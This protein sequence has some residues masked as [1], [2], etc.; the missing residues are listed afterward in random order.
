MMFTGKV[1]KAVRH[2]GY[3]TGAGVGA[4]VGSYAVIEGLKYAGQAAEAMQ[5]LPAPQ[6]SALDAVPYIVGGLAA[7]ATLVHNLRKDNSTVYVIRP[8][9]D[10]AK[11]A[12]KVYGSAKD[13]ASTENQGQ[14]ERLIDQFSELASTAEQKFMLFFDK[15]RRD[16]VYVSVLERSGNDWKESEVRPVYVLTKGKQ[17]Y[18]FKSMDAYLEWCKRSSSATEAGV[19]LPGGDVKDKSAKKTKKGKKEKPK[20]TPKEDKP[21]VIK[22]EVTAKAEAKGDKSETVTKKTKADIK[23]D[24]EGAKVE[25]DLPVPPESTVS[26]EE[27]G[28]DI[29]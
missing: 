24:D 6:V 14:L 20:K 3:A 4:G 18:F 25:T 26:D 12:R 2:A 22:V 16:T 1:R 9:K 27:L 29:F 15:N 7:I 17:P 23:V 8:S 28:A 13:F 5:R 11:Q 19:Y 21:T 10:P